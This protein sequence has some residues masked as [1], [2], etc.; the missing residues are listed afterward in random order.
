MLQSP[1][2]ILL[3]AGSVLKELRLWRL[4]TCS[5]CFLVVSFILKQ[6]CYCFFSGGRE[7][8]SND[9]VDSQRVLGYEPC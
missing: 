3:P 6:S 4:S 7:A 9:T 1:N 2:Q 8:G 5:I